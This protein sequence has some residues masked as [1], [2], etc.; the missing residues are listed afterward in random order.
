MYFGSCANK[1]WAIQKRREGRT[2][3]RAEIPPSAPDYAFLRRDKDAIMDAVDGGHFDAQ[4]PVR[5]EKVDAQAHSK[6]TRHSVD[7]RCFEGAKTRLSWGN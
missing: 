4:L 6:L 1:E 3:I 5:M 2:S 7:T